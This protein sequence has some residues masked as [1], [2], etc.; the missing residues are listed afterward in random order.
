MYKGR[1]IQSTINTKFTFQ[2]FIDNRNNSI[3]IIN[4]VNNN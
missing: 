1:S 3:I 4:N 2:Y